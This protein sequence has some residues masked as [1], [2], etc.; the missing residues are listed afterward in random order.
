MK[1][2]ASKAERFIEKDRFPVYAHYC[3]GKVTMR[4]FVTEAIMEGVV[5]APVGGGGPLGTEAWQNANVNN[6]TND[7]QYDEISGFP[8]YKTL[9]CQVKKRNGSGAATPSPIQPLVVADRGMGECDQLL[10]VAGDN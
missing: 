1:R 10:P 2:V 9:L 5:Y 7:R 8:V 6:L 3:G 4:A